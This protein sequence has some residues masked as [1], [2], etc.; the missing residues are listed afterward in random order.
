MQSGIITLDWSAEAMLVFKL[1]ASIVNS[2]TAQTIKAV[3]D[4]QSLR[5]Q[6]LTNIRDRLK[7]LMSLG[8]AISEV[9]NL[10]LF[11]PLGKLSVATSVG[12]VCKNRLCLCQ[13]SRQRAW[14]SCDYLHRLLTDL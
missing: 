11:R 13:C 9:S 6:K 12:H 1:H 5:R 3:V 8:T 2:K 4:Y 14:S 10:H 7:A